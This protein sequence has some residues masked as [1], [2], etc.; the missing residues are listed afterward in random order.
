MG[1]IKAVKPQSKMHALK[2]VAVVLA[3]IMWGGYALYEFSYI[4]KRFHVNG[5]RAGA[6]RFN[7]SKH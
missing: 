6:L 3:F 1:Q 4:T 7:S 2:I 5:I